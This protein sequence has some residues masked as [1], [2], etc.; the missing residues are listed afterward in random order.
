[1]VGLY[2]VDLGQSSKETQGGFLGNRKNDSRFGLNDHRCKLMKEIR[3]V[4]PLH[5]RFLSLR[6]FA[7]LRTSHCTLPTQHI[8]LCTSFP[9]LS[10]NH[11]ELGLELGGHQ[12]SLLSDT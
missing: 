6:W 12:L 3:A 9:L 4:L 10:P 2:P 11:L 5:R 1:M 8:T 7:L